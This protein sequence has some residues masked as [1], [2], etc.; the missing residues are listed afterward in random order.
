[1]SQWE[2]L[3]ALIG[4][5]ANTCLGLLARAIRLA[6]VLLFVEVTPCVY[7]VCAGGVV[8]S[9]GI[10]ETNATARSTEN[11]GDRRWRRG[12]ERYRDGVA[13]RPSREGPTVGSGSRQDSYDRY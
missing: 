2:R 3:S 1:M 8:A 9:A 12:A 13:E 11:G 5:M 7:W 4:S 10:G 6:R